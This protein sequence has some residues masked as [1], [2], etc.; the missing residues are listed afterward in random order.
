MNKEKRLI[1]NTIIITIG[2]ISTSLITFLLLPLYTTFLSTKEYGIVDLV[3][4][5]VILFLPIMSLQIDQGVFRELIDIR[6]NEKAKSKI[7]STGTFLLT[8][9]SI[10]FVILYLFLAPFIKNNYKTLL[11]TNLIICAYLNLFQQIARGLGDNN[12]Y[13]ID[14]FICSLFTIIFTIIFIVVF[15]LGASGMLLGTI[16]GQLVGIVYFI[17]SLKLYKYIRLKNYTKNLKKIIWKYSIPLIPNAIAWWLLGASDAVIVS[18]ILGIDSNGILAA[19]L[20]FSTIIVT[21][22]GIFNISWH[23]SAAL[24]INDDDFDDFF[25]KTINILFKLFLSLDVLL[26]AFM[27]FIFS[28]MVNKKYSMGYGLIPI[29]IVSSLFNVLQGLVVVVFAAK[30]DTKNI[31]ITSMATAI[32][33]IVLHLLLIKFIGL[34]ASV[35]S[36]FI[37]LLL[38]SIYRIYVINKKYFKV[39]LESKTFISG[40]IIISFLMVTFY[41]NNLYLNILSI[42]IAIFYSF[43]L[44]K[45]SI[46]FVISILKNKFITRKE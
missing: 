45:N 30:K 17:I 40:T 39:K 24:S 36:T 13:A 31:A 21:L 20:K 25:N 41:L 15:K 23:E 10:L 43:I 18:T 28:I 14:T 33:N 8:I 34:Y 42:F 38:L 35:I 6:N 22:Y 29:S 27:P 3:N 7:I 12:K 37:S 9:Q 32:I 11:I 5:L 2:K 46:D 16:F 1:K 44:N 26:L 19:S 4:T